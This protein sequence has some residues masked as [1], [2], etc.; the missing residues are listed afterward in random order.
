MGEERGRGRRRRGRHRG[1]GDRVRADPPRAR[2]DRAG[3]GD[4]RS[5]GTRPAA[6]PASSTPASTTRP[7]SLKA[8]L[9]T[10]RGRVD[11]R[12]R[13]RARDPGGH[14]R[15]ARGG[16]PTRAAARAATGC[17]T[18]PGQRGPGA[19]GLTRT[20]RASSSRTS[21]ASRRCGWSRPASSTTSGSATRWRR[22]ITEGGGRLLTG[23]ARSSASTPAPTA[24]RSPRPVG[25]TP[26]RRFV[27]CA[28]LQSD[29]LARL[30]GLEPDVRIV[31]FRGEYFELTPAQRAPGHAG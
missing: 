28:G 27:N 12:L 1:A 10:R 5:P 25:E 24:S 18:R 11:A 13:A 16:H 3:E 19:A 7:G 31:P 2:G 20:R 26:G 14:L 21:P 6:T 8:K 17:S 30:A 22:L 29:R 4:R 15:Q 23:C 9:G